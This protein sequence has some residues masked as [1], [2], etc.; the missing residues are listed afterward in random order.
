MLKFAQ[1]GDT[2]L[3]RQMYG[4]RLLEDQRHALDLVRRELEERDVDV[5]LITG[6]VYDRSVPPAEAVK[7]LDDFV[8]DVTQ[9]LGIPIVMIAGNHDSATRLEF[10]GRLMNGLHIAPAF[11]GPIEPIVFEDE[12][13]MIEVFPVPFLEPARVRQLLED[14]AVVDQESAM[15]AVVDDIRA[16]ATAERVV[17]MGHAFV[18]GGS[19]S[20]SERPLAIGGAETIDASVFDGISYVALGHLHRPQSVG[21]PRVQYAG[22]LMKYSLSELGHDKSMTVVQIPLEGDVA[23][24]RVPLPPLR[25]LRRVEGELEDVIAR[26]PEGDADD[27]IVVKLLDKGPVFDAMARVRTV[28]PN[29]LHIERP[30]IELEGTVKL[31]SRD[32]RSMGIHELFQAFYQEV[33]GEELDAEASEALAEILREDER[34]EVAA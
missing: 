13:G 30:Q 5:L 31:P 12:L 15:R 17:I 25:D 27:Y 16:R 26:G 7:V 1:I 33:M 2:H 34:E 20:E 32:H 23:L 9:G 28:Y 11:Q 19:A 3:G 18:A 14:P 6:D 21:S 4:V 24:E 22:S 10:G 29:A 8:Y